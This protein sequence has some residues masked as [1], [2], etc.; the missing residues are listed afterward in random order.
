MAHDISI[1]Y[2][3]KKVTSGFYGSVPFEPNTLSPQ[4]ETNIFPN[5]IHT[6]TG[7]RL[8]SSIIPKELLNCSLLQ[9]SQLSNRGIPYVK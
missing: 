5:A 7:N 9:G 8:N 2:S 4:N 6:K 1:I 3:N